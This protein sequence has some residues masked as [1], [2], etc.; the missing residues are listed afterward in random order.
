VKRFYR[1][2]GVDVGAQGHR[3]L[4]DGRTVRTP[5]RHELALPHAPL[6]LAVAQEWRAQGDTIEQ[7]SMALTRLASTVLDRMPALRAAAIDEVL[8]YAETDMVCYR[9]A[10]PAD[11]ALRQER[12]WQPWLDWLARTRDVELLVTTAMLPVAQPEAALLRL[13][14]ALEEQDD[15]RL[16]GLHAVTT[17][18]G[19][20][21]L[22]LALFEGELDAEQALAASLLDEHY[23]IER[24][25]REREA[26]RRHQAL[27]RA[28]VAAAEFLACLGQPARAGPGPA[29]SG[30]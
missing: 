2:V 6:A 20:L 17:A 27:Q 22:G 28:L 10:T 29:D 14:A 5:S 7:A 23:E 30:G 9:A 13:R 3:V 8:G 16:V 12:S 25:G 1:E 26:E 19:S 18:L 11:L 21:V 4:L 24:W 15:W